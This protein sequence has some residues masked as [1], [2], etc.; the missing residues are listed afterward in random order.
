MRTQ[1]TCT[2]SIPLIFV[3][4]CN[5]RYSC[6]SSLLICYFLWLRVWLVGRIVTAKQLRCVESTGRKTTDLISVVQVLK[7]VWSLEHNA[8][9]LSF[10]RMQLACILPL[11]IQAIKNV[12]CTHC[13]AHDR[14]QWL[15]LFSSF[16]SVEPSAD[17]HFWKSRMSPNSE[18]DLLQLSEPYHSSFP[19][20]RKTDIWVLQQFSNA[21][22]F[23]LKVC[24]I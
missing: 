18:T 4:K 9:H 1:L 20:W 5:K 12:H 19:K 6:K 13:L 3:N 14:N 8:Q 17:L 21:R 22:L 7:Y 24:R 15:C 11:L 2:F 23:L 16:S 10:P